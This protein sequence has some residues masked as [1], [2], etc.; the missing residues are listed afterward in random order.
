MGA[1]APDGVCYLM[2]QATS[3]GCFSSR[4]NSNY[5]FLAIFAATCAGTVSNPQPFA[6][7]DLGPSALGPSTTV[8]IIRNLSAECKPFL[9]YGPN[10][11]TFRLLGRT[12]N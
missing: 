11:S 4:E 9:R 8:R 5:L 10:I 2:L 7:A 6:S 12:P 3:D 1:R